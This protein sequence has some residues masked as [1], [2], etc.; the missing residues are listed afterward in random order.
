MARG[1]EYDD[2]PFDLGLGDDTDEDDDGLEQVPETLH[3]ETDD[4]GWDEPDET[5]RA[6]A[7]SI[8]DSR[9][10]WSIIHRGDQKLK[11]TSGSAAGRC[12]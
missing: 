6:A 8:N 2:G 9:Q 3:D 11:G 10:G 1:A 5:Q 4:E 7:A 12:W